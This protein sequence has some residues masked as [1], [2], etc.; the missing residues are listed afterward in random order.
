[1]VALLGV[2]VLALGV[3]ASRPLSAPPEVRFD[4]TTPEVAEP[5][6]LP[7]VALSADGRQILFVADSDGQPHVWLR[8]I[9]SVSARP[10]AGTGGA[11]YPFWSPDGRSVAFYADGFLK[12]LDLDGGL[13][14]VLAKAVVGLG[15]T[16]SRDGVILFVRNPASPIVRVSAE[17]GP[18]VDVTRLARRASVTRLPPLSSRWPTLLVLRDGCPGLARDPRGAARWLVVASPPRCRCGCVYTNGHLLFIR[19]TTVFAQ[20]FD[21]ERIELKGAR[22]KSPTECTVRGACSR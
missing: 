17:G 7:S 21:A 16:W 18:A 3:W 14:R 15:G 6:L 12:R 19:Q 5:F 9:N 8:A 22:F 4:I 20:Q 10:L 1:M 11:A 13:V 2:A